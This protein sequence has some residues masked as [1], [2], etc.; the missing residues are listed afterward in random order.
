MRLLALNTLQQITMATIDNVG[1]KILILLFSHCDV[2][3]LDGEHPSTIRNG[4]TAVLC[5]SMK[6][7]QP[8]DPIDEELS[9]TENSDAEYT[10]VSHPWVSVL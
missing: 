6:M 10:A 4:T 2:Q 5:L 8:L 1:F 3:L 7:S 9:T